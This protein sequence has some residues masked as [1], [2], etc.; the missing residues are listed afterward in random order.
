M[1]AR[2]EASREA[3]IDRVDVSH[4]IATTMAVSNA[5]P[6]VALSMRQLK[7]RIVYS[8]AKRRPRPSAGFY[9]HNQ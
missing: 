8:S 1:H 4:R 5:S 3:K 6:D 2:S 9:I 7:H